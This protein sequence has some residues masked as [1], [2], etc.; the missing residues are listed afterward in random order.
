MTALLHSRKFLIL[1]LDTAISLILF[2]VGRY[3]PSA[4]E[5]VR[6]VIGALQPVAVM[7]IAAI[8][9]EDAAEKSAVIV[10]RVKVQ[11]EPEHPDVQ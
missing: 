1:V 4:M 8:A 2:G 10:E 3:W 11:P 6:F 9:W 7:M 5:D